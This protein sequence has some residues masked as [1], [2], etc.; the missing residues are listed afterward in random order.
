M[1]SGRLG[2]SSTSSTSG[3]Q[4]SA[5]YGTDRY[6]LQPPSEC[7]SKMII[8]LMIGW[9]TISLYVSARS[10]K[11]NLCPP[12]SKIQIFHGKNINSL[13]YLPDLGQFWS[14]TIN[15]PCWRNC[16]EVLWSETDICLTFISMN[17]SWYFIVSAV[18]TKIYGFS[19]LNWT[20]RP[21]TYIVYVQI[22][23]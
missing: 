6:Y 18:K 10:K 2:S 5:W 13:E 4:L 16:V 3:H 12:F 20:G 17:R 7:R 11:D 23:A 19:S 9:M 21:Q 22:S 14:M 1:S 15:A 8:A